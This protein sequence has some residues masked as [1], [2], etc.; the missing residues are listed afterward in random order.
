MEGLDEQ[1]RELFTK[2]LIIR[3]EI[4]DIYNAVDSKQEATK[5]VNERLNEL[6]KNKDITPQYKKKIIASESKKDILK[7]K[8][9]WYKSLLYSE[10]NDEKVQILKHY[11]KDMSNDEYKKAAMFL[12]Q[13]K[14]IS[15]EVTKEF[16]IV[17]NKK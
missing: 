8:P 1:R 9:S 2:R 4:E 5:L 10:S 16:A 14:I 11:T 13:N 12:L 17:R 7:D 3:S 6:V 15:P